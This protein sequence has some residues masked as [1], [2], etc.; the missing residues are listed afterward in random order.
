ME[1]VDLPSEAAR[2]IVQ[3]RMPNDNG[4]T[5][6]VWH[7]LIIPHFRFVPQAFEPVLHA[8]KRSSSLVYTLTDG[9]FL[10]WLIDHSPTCKVV[11]R[12]G[13]WFKT[14]RRRFTNLT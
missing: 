1:R 12:N 11:Y 3:A 10:I 13:C 6:I 14:L 9:K 2:S 7:A 4:V 5:V 8:I